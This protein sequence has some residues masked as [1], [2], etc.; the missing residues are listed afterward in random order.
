MNMVPS[1][2]S[3]FTFKGEF[4]SAMSKQDTTVVPEFTRGNAHISELLDTLHEIAD[5]AALDRLAEW[6][7]NT[8]MPGGAAE[9]RGFHMATL[10]GVLHERLTSPRLGGLLDELREKVQESSFTDADRGLVC[11]A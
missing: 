8:A 9:V 3:S 6:D 7:Q 5:L 10:K 1:N 4:K 11:E 2:P